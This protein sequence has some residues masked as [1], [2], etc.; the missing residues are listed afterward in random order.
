MVVIFYPRPRAI[1]RGGEV[2]AHIV[3]AICTDASDSIPR[4]REIIHRVLDNRSHRN[5][6]G[7]SS[8]R[9]NIM[10]SVY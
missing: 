9:P 1:P 6:I 2:A 3:I 7:R 4:S 5:M 10:M 8:R